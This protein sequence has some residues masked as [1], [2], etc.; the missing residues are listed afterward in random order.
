MAAEFKFK[1]RLYRNGMPICSLLPLQK[2]LPTQLFHKMYMYHCNHQ[3]DSKELRLHANIAG[4]GSLQPLK[5]SLNVLA[6]FKMLI[7]KPN[8]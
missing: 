4:M 2:C 8:H 5:K 1:L 7:I 3:T 6:T